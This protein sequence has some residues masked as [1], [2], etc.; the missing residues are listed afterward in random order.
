MYIFLWQQRHQINNVENPFIRSRHNLDLNKFDYI[1]VFLVCPV[2]LRRFKSTHIHHFLYLFKRSLY[3]SLKEKLIYSKMQ[4]ADIHRKSPRVLSNKWFLIAFLLF[5]F[6]LEWKRNKPAEQRLIYQK[7]SVHYIFHA[8]CFLS[9]PLS[10]INK[11]ISIATNRRIKEVNYEH[12]IQTAEWLEAI[13]H[14]RGWNLDEQWHCSVSATSS[15]YVTHPL[16]SAPIY[17][18]FSAF[19]S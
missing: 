19:F 13:I 4:H 10:E 18:W 14:L 15:V 8:M 17:F 16:S 5:S 3:F 1:W 11:W 6:G 12:L 9:L 2:P 7:Q